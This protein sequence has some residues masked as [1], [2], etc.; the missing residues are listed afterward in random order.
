MMMQGGIQFGYMMPMRA[1]AQMQQQQ[2]H[3][4]GGGGH[5]QARLPLNGARPHAEGQWAMPGLG[6][7]HPGTRKRRSRMATIASATNAGSGF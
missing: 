1:M 7:V 6:M 3:F 2:R 4:Q 5:G